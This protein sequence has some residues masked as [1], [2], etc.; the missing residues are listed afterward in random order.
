MPGQVFIGTELTGGFTT[1]L[2]LDDQPPHLVVESITPESGFR[3]AGLRL[4][5]QI[6]A[7]EGEPISRIPLE[8]RGGITPRLPGQYQECQRW[9]DLG[10]KEGSPIRLTVRRKAF[11]QGWQTL[12]IQGPL[13]FARNYRS[14]DN[15]TLAFENGPDNYERDGFY[16]GWTSWFDQI[17]KT[18]RSVACFGRGRPG[19]TT[20]YELRTLLEQKP[21]VDLLVTKYPGRVASATESDFNT[22]VEALRGHLYSLTS[23]DLAYRKADEERYSAVAAESQSAWKQLQSARASEIIAA[24]PAQHPI[25]G[26]R[27]EVHGKCVVLERLTT[28]QWVSE[29][30]H[31]YF[32]AGSDSDGWY[33]LD[34]EGV[35]AQRMLRALR[36]FQRM[37]SSRIREE[38]TL[39]AR[40]IPEARVLVINDVGHWGLQVELLAAIVGDAMFIDVQ[41][42][43][44]QPLFSGEAALQLCH[45]PEPAVDATPAQVLEAM[46]AAIKA[47]DITRWKS[48][49][50][51]WLIRTNPDGSPQVCYRMQ[52][53]RDDDFERSRAS[54]AGRLWDARVA[55]VDDPRLVTT[56]T[57]FPGAACVEEVEAE[58]EHLGSFNGEYR[59]FMDVTVNRFWTLQR[60]D[61]GP[62]RIASLQQI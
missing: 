38:Y 13:Q 42:E 46:I 39:L 30:A 20:Q 52:E 51:D 12:D 56:G 29:V 22:T 54:F 27:D 34:M 14:E 62:W 53:V 15:R 59:S 58:I 55:W 8:R 19:I 26:K 7:A 35:G 24:F 1:E 11:P 61:G 9:V 40:I 4:G 47:D 25:H 57:E 18:F 48:L 21:R 17:G 10:L 32:A 50:A 43:D 33:F 31:G 36:R 16:D 5:D 3:A 37:V 28:R 2:R 23:S 44:P 45:N 6:L 60:I 41:A 49:F